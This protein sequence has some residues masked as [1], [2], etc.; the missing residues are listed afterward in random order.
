MPKNEYNFAWVTDFPLLDFDEDEQRHVAVHHP[1]TSPK[2]ADLKL[3]DTA[4][5]KAK[6]KAY[7]LTL[8][9]VENGGGAKRNQ[10]PEAS[11][12]IFNI[13]GITDEE[14]QMKFGFLLEAFKYGAPPHGGI[15]F[16]VDRIAAILTN[17]ESIR[18]VI[19]F[20]KN[21][22]AQNPM[23]GSPA[24]VDDEQLKELDIKLGFVKK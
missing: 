3:L 9:G 1:F 17:N 4:P 24:E 18:E 14:A 6:A 5:E 15:A 23:D 10:K 16:G 12:K 21:K 8:N 20:P 7:D 19:A 11:A 2:D 13:L 22:N